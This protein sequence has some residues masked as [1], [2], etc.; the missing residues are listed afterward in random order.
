MYSNKIQFTAE[1]IR[2]I[3]RRGEE[4]AAVHSGQVADSSE[5]D[6]VPSEASVSVR[7]SRWEPGSHAATAGGEAR[8]PY[9]KPSS[10]LAW[11]SAPTASTSAL[12]CLHCGCC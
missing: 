8:E 1:S 5:G 11:T 2:D 3:F 9:R 4:E 6:K 10:R 7:Q 12:L